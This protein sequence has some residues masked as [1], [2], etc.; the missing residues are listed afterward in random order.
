MRAHYGVRG[1]RYKL[2]RFYGEGLDAW[3]FYD[4]KSDPHEMDNRIGD[5]AMKAPIAAMKRRL[6]ELRR[7]Y[8]DT[9][10]PAIS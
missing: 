9:S 7:E 10:G 5:P 8:E 3:E 2:V 6:V 4:L 1:E